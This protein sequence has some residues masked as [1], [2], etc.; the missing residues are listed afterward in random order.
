MI[1]RK[2]LIK[3]FMKKL[4]IKSLLFVLLG[5]GAFICLCLCVV[6]LFILSGAENVDGLVA[7]VCT[8]AVLMPTALLTSA[9][10]LARSISKPLGFLAGCISDIAETGNIFLDDYAYKQTK[11]LNG[12]KDEIGK[13]SRSIGD[14]LAMFRDKIKSLNA[15]K[16]GDLTTIINCRSQKDT[17]GSA[18]VKMTESLNIMFVD[19]Q[20]ASNHMAQGSF[21][22]NDDVL[23]LAEVTSEQADEIGSLSGQI[24]KVAEQTARNS[25]MA[26]E[27]SQLSLAIK[28][29]AQKGGEQMTQMT[30][31][32]SQINESSRAISRVIKIID[33]IAFQTNILALNAAVEAARAGEAGKGFAVVADEVRNLASKSAEAAKETGDLIANS[34]EKAELGSQIAEETAASLHEIVERITESTE[35][36]VKIAR[37]SEAQAT[38]IAGIDKGIEKINTTVQKNSHTAEESARDSKEISL[39]SERLAEFIGKFKIK[40]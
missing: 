11:V 38:A 7:I 21:K 19:I 27:S 32:V 3:I 14:M 15:V 36:A 37:S 20:D 28:E 31:A 10:L 29:L 30:D 40:T 8:F 13:I 34:L 18:L 17:V 1:T 9:F 5:G 24:G 22:M 23:A 33:S 25:E 6:M 4:S 26:A 16:D 35:L 39:Q 2:D 12:R